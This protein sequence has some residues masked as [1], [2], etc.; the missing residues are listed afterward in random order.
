M[1][2][3]PIVKATVQS[4]VLGGIANV[5]AQLF[6]SYRLDVWM[7]SWGQPYFTPVP[8]LCPG[9]ERLVMGAAGWTSY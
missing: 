6:R 1:A 4:A 5:L 9:A 8:A 2:L 7:V 3:S